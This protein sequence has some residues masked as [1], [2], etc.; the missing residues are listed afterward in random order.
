MVFI[1]LVRLRFPFGCSIAE[2][3]RKRYGIK[4]LQS[5]RKFEKADVKH[6]KAILDLEFLFICKDFNVIPKFLHFKLANSNLRSSA[7]Y[8]RCQR[9]LLLEEI[10]NKRLLIK[11]LEKDSCVRYKNLK[12]ELSIIDFHHV[13]NLT[14][15][16]N[17]KTLARFKYTH[18]KKLRNLIPNF[19]W[20]LVKKTSHDL[21]KVIYNFSS[22]NLNN[23]DKL[24]LSKGL[25]FAIP[26]KQIDYSGYLTEFELLY[27]SSMDLSLTAEER[28]RF[29][30]KLKD[31]ALTSQKFYNDN[32]KFENNLS[33]EEVQ[34]LK[35]LMKEKNIVIQK[36][37]KGN[38]VVITDK[39]NYIKGIA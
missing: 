1:F 2:I 4:T 29:K 38:T 6:K 5:L 16:C 27:R 31:I 9:R 10:Y 12:S 25:Q 20:D 28:E 13:L 11:K 23:N 17:E 26:P 15:T 37:D 33:L 21:N 39:D 19:T 7:T 30:T 35:S 8:K 24:L 18:L 34:S 32:C 22:Y 14:L 36:A 3:L